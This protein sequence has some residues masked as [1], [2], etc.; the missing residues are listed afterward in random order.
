MLHSTYTISSPMFLEWNF[1]DF[2]AHIDYHNQCSEKNY[3]HVENAS[4]SQSL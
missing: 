2:A 4:V 1:V 3:E